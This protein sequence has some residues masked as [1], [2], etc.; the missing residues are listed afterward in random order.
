MSSFPLLGCSDDTASHLW[1]VSLCN[2]HLSEQLVTANIL[3]D[4]TIGC[5]EPEYRVSYDLLPYLFTYPAS[6]AA[7]T[8]QLCAA[9]NHFSSLLNLSSI[10]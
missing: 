4:G 10:I 9:A 2:V 1:E 3:P 7:A 6:L 8:S 5:L